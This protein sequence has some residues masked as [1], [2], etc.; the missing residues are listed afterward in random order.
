MNMDDQKAAAFVLR[1]LANPSLRDLLPLQKE[2][3]VLQF[4]KVNKKALLPTL[5]SSNFFPGRNWDEIYL[6]LQQALFRETDKKVKPELANY[7]QK[8]LDL[9][10]IS[11]IR[12]QLAPSSQVKEEIISIVNKTLAKPAC[13]A[14][15]ADVHTALR[16]RMPE[17]Y[18]N[19]I[20]QR[21]TYIF[22]ELTKVQ[23]LIKMGPEEIKNFVKL[24]LLL[25]PA[26]KLIPIEYEL[27][28]TMS[29]DVLPSL[30][31]KKAIQVI[32]QLI[33]IL[34]PEIVRSGLNSTLSFQENKFQEA[35]ARLAGVLAMRCR[36]YRP[37]IKADRGAETSDKSWFSI[38][39]RNYKFYG[40]DVDLLTE[41][42]NI[43]AENGW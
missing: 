20:S 43:A 7:V 9:S 35:T 13:R 30:F 23:R 28:E 25:R 8:S 33:K 26:V 41:L 42:Y 24:S 2:E 15:L 18:I 27:D 11:F 1:L 31:V 22:F 21:R 16:Y 38:A 40:Y 36:N 19:A 5:S 6:I 12:Q 34:P 3:Q 14:M 10:F 32:S 4:L 17:K 39:R 29:P 37:Q